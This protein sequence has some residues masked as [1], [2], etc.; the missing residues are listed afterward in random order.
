MSFS[1]NDSGTVDQRISGNNSL[2]LLVVHY[3]ILSVVIGLAI[4]KDGTPT[5]IS[6]S[7]QAEFVAFNPA[8]AA[9]ILLAQPALDTRTARAN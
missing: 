3:A 8:S 9:P 7:V 5:L 6:D 1:R 4:G 2:K